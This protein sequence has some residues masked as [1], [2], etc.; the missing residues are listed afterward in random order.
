LLGARPS[1]PKPAPNRIT[2]TPAHR[3]AT[4]AV[5]YGG[6]AKEPFNTSGELLTSVAVLD[7]NNERLRLPI[8]MRF[9]TLEAMHNT[10]K[11]LNIPEHE[12]P[13]TID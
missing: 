6:A 2:A 3:I 1:S 4:L 7:E 8:P 13:Q 5:S 10:C 9:A 12:W 11:A